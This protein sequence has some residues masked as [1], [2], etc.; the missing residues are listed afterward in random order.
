MPLTFETV[1]QGC[2]PCKEHV[3]WIQVDL[4]VS[5]QTAISE[6]IWLEHNVGNEIEELLMHM[7]YE[8]IVDKDQ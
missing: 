2:L 4:S 5:E 7:D 8:M 6:Q 1:H 3:V